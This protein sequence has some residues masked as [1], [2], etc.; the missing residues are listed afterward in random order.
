MAALTESLLIL[1]LS[2]LREDR[3]NLLLSGQYFDM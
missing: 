1:S 2:A 3:K